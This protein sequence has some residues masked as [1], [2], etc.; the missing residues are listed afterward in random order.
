MNQAD[1]I[2]EILEIASRIKL[3]GQSLD[4]VTLARCEYIKNGGCNT[5]LSAQ[6][7]HTIK[8]CVQGWTR[9]Q[10]KGIWETS[11][12]GLCFYEETDEWVDRILETELLYHI[13][14]SFCPEGD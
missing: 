9:E 11:I 2:K 8:E 1:A 13:V 10:K 4:V 3:P 14:D 7:E 5:E 6:I 12:K